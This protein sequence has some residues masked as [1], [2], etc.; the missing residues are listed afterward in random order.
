M[1]GTFGTHGFSCR[2]SA[3]RHAMLKD[4][5]HGALPS[6]NVPSQ[7]EPTGLDHADNKRPDGITMVPW[8]NGRS[9]VWDATFCPFPSIQLIS[10]EQ[11]SEVF[12]GH[13]LQHPLL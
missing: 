5:L 2:F 11:D 12:W 7:L 4:I 3:G 10:K 6:V 9:L 8:S 13:C 1:D